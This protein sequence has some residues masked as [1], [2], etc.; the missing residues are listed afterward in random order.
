[1]DVKKYLARIGVDHVPAP[2]VDTLSLLQSAHLMHVPY[3]NMDILLG[4]PIVLEEQALFEKIVLK[5][6]GG[7]CFELNEL[8][9]RLLRALGYGVTDLFGRFLKGESEIPMRR[10]HVLLVDVP[11][12]TDRFVC[13]VGVGSGS[14]TWPVRLVLHEEQP[15]A[16]GGLYRFNADPFLSFV[17]EENKRGLWG[18]V[19]SFT[20]EPQLPVDF[21]AAS[22][23]CEKSPESIFNK[24]EMLSLRRP[25]GGRIT[26][27]GSAF[28]VFSESGVTEQIISDPEQ[29][30]ARI[31]QWFGIV[32]D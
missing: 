10:H 11:G 14:P 15:Q 3:E 23:F 1:M 25:G 19:Y 20:L 32:P 21:A 27:D 17:L 29:K 31:A 13:D 4:R 26:L 28:R 7:Y 18:P 22:F 16:D 5:N 24:E 12:E 6:R 8:F 30:K 2:T 9:G